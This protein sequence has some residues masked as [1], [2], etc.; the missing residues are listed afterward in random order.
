MTTHIT[1]AG[2]NVFADLGFPPEEAKALKAESDRIIA[3]K[4]AI[5][6]QLAKHLSAWIRDEKMT[7]TGAA[8]ALG[9]ARCR[10]SDAVGGKLSELTIDSLLE[11]LMRAGK[12][13]E[14]SI[15]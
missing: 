8:R 4:L 3:E 12:H 5:K 14:L 9:V 10:V 6:A 13:V 2:G 7:Q 15:R 11:M 1:P